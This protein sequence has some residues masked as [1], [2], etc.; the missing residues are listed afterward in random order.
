[1]APQLR[2]R[3]L[4]PLGAEPLG[5][6]GTQKGLLPF[7]LANAPATAAPHAWRWRGNCAAP[8]SLL[9]GMLS[10]T[11]PTGLVQVAL[12]VRFPRVLPFLQAGECP[13][14]N[15]GFEAVPRCWVK[16]APAFPQCKALPAAALNAHLHV[17]LKKK[18]KALNIKGKPIFA[19]TQSS[20]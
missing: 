10:L 7:L 1:M 3:S 9:C 13:S 20:S 17:C 5:I 12:S 6:S 18:K 11:F 16:L 8:G 19:W 2:A 14:G 15:L 4:Q